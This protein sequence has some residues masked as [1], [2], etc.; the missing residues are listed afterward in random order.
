MSL[1]EEIE[2][3]NDL[4]LGRTPASW[5]EWALLAKNHSF[6][7]SALDFAHQRIWFGSSVAINQDEPWLDSETNLKTAYTFGTILDVTGSY[8]SS[9]SAY[10]GVGS[11]VLDNWVPEIQMQGQHLDMMVEKVQKNKQ[12]F[13]LAQNVLI[14]INQCKFY[15]TL[16]LNFFENIE[17]IGFVLTPPRYLRQALFPKLVA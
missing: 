11:V 5:V 7:S 14:T 4:Y 9:I 16:L 2:S 15:P 17:K 10:A 1:L 12:P 8:I 3:I 13:P 6:L